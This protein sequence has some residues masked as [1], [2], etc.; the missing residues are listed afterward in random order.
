MVRGATLKVGTMCGRVWPRCGPLAIVVAIEDEVG[1][2]W[3]G[4]WVGGERGIRGVKEGEEGMAMGGGGTTRGTCGRG[5]IVA[6]P[7]L[8]GRMLSIIGRGGA[9]IVAERENVVPQCG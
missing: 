6:W 1:G 8:I 4:E 5:C 2:G 9:W 3:W 7:T